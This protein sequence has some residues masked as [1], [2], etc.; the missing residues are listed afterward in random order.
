MSNRDVTD[1][2][3]RT[4]HAQADSVAVTPAGAAERTFWDRRPTRSVTV[5]RPALAAA[6]AALV[7][8]LAV[9]ALFLTRG[10]RAPTPAPPAVPT[11]TVTPS[12]VPSSVADATAHLI[13][14]GA[15]VGDQLWFVF[16]DRLVRMT[17]DGRRV[18][19]QQLPEG[20]DA[21]LLCCVQDAG[22]VVVVPT[23]TGYSFRDVTTGRELTSSTSTAPGPSAVVGDGVWTRSDVDQLALV[24]PDTGRRL[25]TVPA[26]GAADV[27]AADERRLYV[28]SQDASTVS[29]LDPESG[30]PD[31]S[32]RLGSPPR[33]LAVDGTLLYVADAEGGLAVL[34]A[35]TGAVRQRWRVPAASQGPRPRLAVARDAVWWSPD[36]GTVVRLRAAD[37]MVTGAVA[38]GLDR[39]WDN[40]D[41]QRNGLYVTSSGIWLPTR[42]DGDDYEFHRLPLS[43]LEP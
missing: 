37:G 38:V 17:E 36:A 5:R 4:L 34:D 16:G 9:G 30:A 24:S 29:G 40:A 35:E 8:V 41:Q 27:L 11:R 1:V 22:D 13:G 6:A 28:A 3:I 39:R 25:R 7:V 19:S 2:L 33:A 31:W 26:G 15:V 14:N 23:S 20:T 42:N 32:R 10:D 12:A 18:G 43:V 21:E